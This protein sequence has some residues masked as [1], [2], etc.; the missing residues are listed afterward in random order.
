[1]IGVG[2]GCIEDLGR[3]NKKEESDIIAFLISKNKTKSC[4]HLRQA[5]SQAPD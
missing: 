3:R 4:L 2:G 1:M 5:L